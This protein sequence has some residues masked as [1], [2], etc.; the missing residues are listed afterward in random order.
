MTNI[1]R[2]T[3]IAAVAALTIAAS[4]PRLH[5]PCPRRALPPSASASARW[6]SVPLQPTP[7]TMATMAT[8][9]MAAVTAGTTAAPTSA[10]PASAHTASAGTHGAGSAACHAAASDPLTKAT[11]GNLI[12]SAAG[13]PP[14]AFFRSAVVMRQTGR[15]QGSPPAVFRM[16]PCPATAASATGRA[17]H[18]TN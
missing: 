16:P 12:D 18:I 4:L 5:R 2:N 8:A 3:A 9:I 7:T 13:N 17:A 11:A 1:I 14:A 6:Q 15:R 10:L